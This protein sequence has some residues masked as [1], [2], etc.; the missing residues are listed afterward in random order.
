MSE[1]KIEQVFKL[2]VRQSQAATELP[3]DYIPTDVKIPITY[4]ICEKDL[5]MP[6]TLQEALVASIPGCN[7]ERINAGHSPFLSKTV[8]CAQLLIKVA[9]EVKATDTNQIGALAS[10]L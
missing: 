6:L 1:E 9:G 8:E 7:V 5:A 4:I 2:L 10:R 3:I